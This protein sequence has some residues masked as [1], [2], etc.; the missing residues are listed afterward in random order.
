[1]SDDRKAELLDVALRVFAEHGVEGTSM[2]RLAHEADVSCA[3]F[4]HYFRSKEDV[5]QLALQRHGL[6]PHVGA[7]LAAAA[8]RPA[9]EV[10][11]EMARVIDDAMQE[12]R[13]LVWLFLNE[14]RTRPAVAA[15]MDEQNRL[16]LQAVADYL[17]GRVSA[18]ELRPHDTRAAAAVLL[19]ALTMKYLKATPMAVDVTGAVGDLLLRGFLA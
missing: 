14:S 16:L 4:Y 7:F 8:D 3:L 9:T 19:S 17:D 5:L 1:M 6:G 11:P 10:L 15:S 12:R 18:G 2:K 13:H